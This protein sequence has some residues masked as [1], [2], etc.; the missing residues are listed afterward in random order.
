MRARSPMR[1]SLVA[2]LGLLA[3]VVA[4]G[5]TTE[6]LSEAAPATPPAQA[7]ARPGAARAGGCILGDI[8]NDGLV[9]IRD[10]GLWR[11]NFGQTN[12][13]NVADLDANCLVDTRDYGIWRQNFGATSPVTG[14]VVLA[15]G[16]SIV[17]GPAGQALSIPAA[18]TATSSGGAVTD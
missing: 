14:A 18:F 1:L 10:Y 4:A 17:G 8:N 16:A 9:D 7:T 2:L 12:C 5:G 13:G 6:L 3:V 15:G 11:Q